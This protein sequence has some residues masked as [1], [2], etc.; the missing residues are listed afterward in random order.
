MYESPSDNDIVKVILNQE[1]VDNGVE[2]II[3]RSKKKTTKKAM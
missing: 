1:C 3:E 2:P